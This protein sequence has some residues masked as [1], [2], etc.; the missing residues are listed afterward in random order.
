[1]RSEGM[2]HRGPWTM[3]QWMG[4]ASALVLSQTACT[5]PGAAGPPVQALRAAPAAV[6]AA[7]DCEKTTGYDVV[8]VGAGLSGLTASKELR[9]G[10]RDKVLILEATDR[11]GG[12]ASTLKQGPPIDLGGAWIHGVSVNPLTGLADAMGLERVTSNLLGPIYVDDGTQVTQ[13]EGAA[14]QKYEGLE[15]DFI[16]KL[17]ESAAIQKALKECK[18][19]EELSAR[20]RMAR[21]PAQDPLCQELKK[22]ANDKTSDYLPTD[23]QFRSLLAGNIGPL[24]SSVEI[25]QV[26]SVEAVAF[27]AGDDDLL[28]EGMGTFVERLGQQEPVCLNS[29]V[30]KIT[31]RE[32]GVELEVKNG[33]RY[34][35]RKALVTVSTGALQKKKI[36]FDPELPAKKREAIAGL[37]MGNMQ[38]VI[39][40]F[41]DQ[42]NLLGNTPPDSWVLYQGP[43]REVMAFVIK[44]LGKNIAVGFY[45]GQQAQAFE[46]QCA[47]AMVDKDKPLPPQRQ[48]CDEAAVQRAR[49]A[50][51]RMYGTPGNDIGAAVDA[52]DIYMTRWSLDPWSAGAYSAARPG[53]WAMRDE[54]AKPIS[55]YELEPKT[56]AELPRGVNRVYFGGEAS[57]RA[58]Y[59]GSFAGAYEAGL[60]NAR[61]LIQSLAEEEGTRRAIPRRKLVP[62]GY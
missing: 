57:G 47:S 55:Y 20:T 11:I 16:Q 39:I 38:K 35:A 54:M 37:P 17:I 7:V 50:L 3:C 29:P 30:T 26:S 45:G 48:P 61:Q 25:D 4:W 28:K 60:F 56:G 9:K 31:Y 18:D 15:E 59:N 42:G 1:M 2:R 21:M 49:A 14:Y 23:P 10:G 8:I 6:P 36:Q 34:Q 19:S 53:A 41:K 22:K 13:L 52:A 5:H 43:S 62:L 27:E 33:K 40:D 24:E 12:R 58:M 32:D 51:I 44:P 46:G